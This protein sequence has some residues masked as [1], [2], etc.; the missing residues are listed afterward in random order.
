MRVSEALNAL[1]RI[2]PNRGLSDIRLVSGSLG[3]SFRACCPLHAGERVSL[4]VRWNAGELLLECEA[5]CS[6]EHVENYVARFGA[7]ARRQSRRRRP[8]LR[9]ASRVIDARHLFQQHSSVVSSSDHGPGP[10]ARS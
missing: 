10:F 8:P 6:H 2:R 4:S 5:G 1:A 9:L 7:G 3:R